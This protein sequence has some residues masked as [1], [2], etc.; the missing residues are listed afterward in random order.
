MNARNAVAIAT[1]LA[2][3]CGL[4]QEEKPRQRTILY[5]IPHKP[6]EEPENISRRLCRTVKARAME[7]VADEF[8]SQ[9][10]VIRNKPTDIVLYEKTWMKPETKDG[11]ARRVEC[12]FVGEDLKGLD[13]EEPDSTFGN[14][15]PGMD[16][17]RPHTRHLKSPLL[18]HDGDLH[19]DGV[20]DFVAQRWGEPEENNAPAH[21]LQEHYNEITRAA[22]QQRFE[23]LVKITLQRFA[24]QPSG[25]EPSRGIPSGF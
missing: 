20:A 4:E 18:L 6:D 16:R 7:N 17:V 11:G 21:A 2:A 24:R 8:T 5:P 1:L 13:I 19:P 3:S 22:L 15:V 10:K 12:K 9:T 14:D 25:V 23:Q